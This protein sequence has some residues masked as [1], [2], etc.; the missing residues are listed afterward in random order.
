MNTKLEKISSDVLVISLPIAIAGAV[1]KIMH[2]NGSNILLL[3]GLGSTAIGAAIKY[4]FQ[5]TEKDLVWFFEGGY[6]FSR[7]NYLSGFK[8]MN[9]EF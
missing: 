6:R 3:V 8:N 1:F 2:F 5:K 9:F 4:F 7:E